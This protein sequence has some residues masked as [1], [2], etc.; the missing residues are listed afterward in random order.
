MIIYI[1][2]RPWGHLILVNQTCVHK[3]FNPGNCIFGVLQISVMEEHSW[4]LILN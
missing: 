4:S 3:D 2:I 1:D